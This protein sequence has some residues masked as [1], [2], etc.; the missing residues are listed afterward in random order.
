MNNP[1]KI[2]RAENMWIM[3]APYRHAIKEDCPRESKARPDGEQMDEPVAR[4][5]GPGKGNTGQKARE[6]EREFKRIIYNEVKQK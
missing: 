4:D 6:T 5:A 3:F 1:S 2:H